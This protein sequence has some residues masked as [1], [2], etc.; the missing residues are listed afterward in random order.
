MSHE[1]RRNMS[2]NTDADA[3]ADKTE[4][5]SMMEQL[6]DANHEIEDLKLQ[7]A[8]FERSSDDL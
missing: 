6:N 4:S 5:K 8:W 3:N 2:I 7:L 1:E